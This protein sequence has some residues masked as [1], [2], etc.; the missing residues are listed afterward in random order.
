M[1]IIE[2]PIA[3]PIATPRATPIARPIA[4]PR[5]TTIA[6]TRATPRPKITKQI[7]E[8]IV[9]EKINAVTTQK[10]SRNACTHTHIS[11]HRHRRRRTIR[12]T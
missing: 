10:Q 9:L 7:N 5:A 2:T 8:V 11:R 4:T 3:R 12:I 6:T 1:H